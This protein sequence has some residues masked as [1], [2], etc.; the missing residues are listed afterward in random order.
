MERTIRY[1]VALLVVALCALAAG[2]G[3]RLYEL[4]IDR[5]DTLLA[6]A[7]K[8]H[9]RTEE[10][11]GRRGTII[12]RQGRELA[13]SIDSA[14]LYV[15]PRRIEDPETAAR[16]LSPV[17]GV[18]RKKLLERI[19]SGEP[20]VWIERR[21]DPRTANAVRGLGLPV[22]PSE[23]LNFKTEGKRFYP[24]G[25]LA[26][27]VVGCTDIDQKGIEGAELVHDELL[28]G[29]PAT[30]LAVRDGSVTR[31][32]SWSLLRSAGRGTWL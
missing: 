8:Q 3:Y 23:A 30:Y 2:I 13:V 17:I 6:K 26:A 21:L 31:C 20:F 14:S 32:S 15:H 4:Q 29:D 1:R 16:L 24:H 10:V 22:G 18:S 11:W 9:E 25:S 5:S 12:D 28:R 7:R 19:R 27:H